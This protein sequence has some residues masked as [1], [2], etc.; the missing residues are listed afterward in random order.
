MS[1]KTIEIFNNSDEWANQLKHLLSKGENLA[2]LHGLT[3]DILDRIY[4]YAFDYHEKGNVT[5]AEIYYKFL[6]IY[7]FENHEYLE[8]FASVCQSKKKYQQA[9][10]LYKLSYNYFPYDDYSVIYRMGQCQIGAKI[11][12]TQCNVSITLLT[13]VRMIVLRVKRRHILNS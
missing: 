13:I 2:L 6:C 3:P 7:A 10:D 5:D 12:I 8:G 9:Y 4:A 11:S 1:T